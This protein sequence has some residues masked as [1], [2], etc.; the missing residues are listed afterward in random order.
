M[1]RAGPY[2]FQGAIAA[3]HATAPSVAETDWP[4]VVRLY[5][6]MLGQHPSSIAAL[7]RAVAVS[8]ADG[9]A[10]GLAAI[11]AIDRA[12]DLE[13]D[14]SAYPYYHSAKG[15]ILLRLDRG[16]EAADCFRAAIDL[17]GSEA[18]RAHLRARLDVALG[19]TCSDG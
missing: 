4:A 13:G 14:L 12:D 17:G 1:G 2:Q 11:D 9:P 15:E 7:N 19:I 18:E 6:V 8:H 16:S 5:D 3:M 10:A